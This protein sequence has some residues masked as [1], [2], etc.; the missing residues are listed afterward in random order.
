MSS[1]PNYKMKKTNMLGIKTKKK[2]IPI[3]INT[4]PTPGKFLFSNHVNNIASSYLSMGRRIQINK[5]IKTSKLI[6]VNT[7]S[8]TNYYTLNSKDTKQTNGSITNSLICNIKNNNNKSEYNSI[9]AI[10]YVNLNSNNNNLSQ[11]QSSEINKINTA[12]SK[13]KKQLS[14]ISNFGVNFPIIPLKVVSDEEKN[15]KFSFLFFSGV[16][17]HENHLAT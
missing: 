3:N 15:T 1:I 10:N 14:T 13:D 16:K 4:N 8:A 5:N 6:H 11:Q 12:N 17:Y 9:N 2:A 7:N